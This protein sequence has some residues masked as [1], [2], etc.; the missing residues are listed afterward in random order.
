MRASECVCCHKKLKRG[1]INHLLFLQLLPPPCAGM[2]EREPLNME[3]DLLMRASAGDS[4]G[5]SCEC[6]GEVAA[7]PLTRAAVHA[8]RAARPRA[9]AICVNG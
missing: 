5:T 9:M 3:R 7:S 2:R 4:A 1:A 6:G 8:A